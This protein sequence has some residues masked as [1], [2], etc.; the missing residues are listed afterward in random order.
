MG[1]KQ[2]GT[3]FYPGSRKKGRMSAE[4]DGSGIKRERVD[5]LIKESCGVV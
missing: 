5:R 3:S 2:C 1:E 4:G